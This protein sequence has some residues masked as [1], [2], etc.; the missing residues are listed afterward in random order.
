[1][2]DEVG[3]TLPPLGLRESPPHEDDAHDFWR[4]PLSHRYGSQTM[5]RIWS[6]RRKR[7]AWRRVWQALAMAESE[8]GLIAP[9]QLR[10][11]ALHV[12]DIDVERAEAIEE[13]IKHD[14]VAELRVFA[15]QCDA[16]GHGAGGVLHL[17]ATSMDIE[18]NADVRRIRTALG[19]IIGRLAMMIEG[20]SEHIEATADIA[21]MGFTH[22]Q[23]AEPT[24][25]GY[26]LAQLGQ[27]LLEDYRELTRLYAGLR[28]K[29]LKGACGTSASYVELMGSTEAARALEARVME[30][31]GL[32][33]YE[34]AT[35]TYPRKQDLAVVSALASMAQSFYKFAFDLRFL[36]MP[37]IG[38]LSE[39]F[40]SHQIGSSAMP[41]KRN[42]VSAEN[43]CSL[44]RQLAALPRIAWD[45]AAH[46]LLE[47]TL[48]DSANR[49]SLLP[50]AFLLAD[51]IVERMRR[52]LDGL[53]H[54]PEATERLLATYGVFAAT[55]KVLMEAARAGGDRQVL[56]EVLR[57]QAM[58]AWAV[59]ARGEKNPLPDLLANDVRITRWVPAERLPTLLDARTHVG[60]APERAR[61]MAA[62]MRAA[63]TEGRAHDE[64]ARAEGGAG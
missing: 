62:M 13:E 20:L 57:D 12:D 47:R 21:T 26:R 41:F 42:P 44:A 48:D 19:L 32:N 22:L 16:H 40:G 11:I 6:E 61:R 45:N 33:A 55:E 53:V 23:P 31:L 14:L 50:E 24:T 49:R 46:S 17:G 60:D 37:M 43:I 25:I 4:S 56:H 39:P 2:S 1:M 27:D 5:R 59:V 29:G 51:A 28:G 36:Q 38:E 15:A 34:A 58:I 10:D 64:R 52:V 63:V 7:I 30:L 35:Q 54:T 3:A 9:S 8:V 18:D